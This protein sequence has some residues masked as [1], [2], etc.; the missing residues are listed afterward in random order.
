MT[1]SLAV[2]FRNPSIRKVGYRQYDDAEVEQLQNELTE[3]ANQLREEIRNLFDAGHIISGD[4]MSEYEGRA[5]NIFNRAADK[6]VELDGFKSAKDLIKQA[7]APK[8]PETKMQENAARKEQQNQS[9]ALTGNSAVILALAAQFRQD[10]APNSDI[11]GGS[12]EDGY[13]PSS[14]AP[15][16]AATASS[17]SLPSL[18]QDDEHEQGAA[19][20]MAYLNPAILRPRFVEHSDESMPNGMD[21]T[22][23]K[24][25]KIATLTP[26]LSQRRA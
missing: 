13:M 7:T 14:S 21:A 3:E 5:Q 18:S 6:N 19:P 24:M 8:D 1:R 25:P 15:Q 20:K 16:I 12:N 22:L 26:S 4:Q 11:S 23:K 9:I 17:T 2:V 10:N